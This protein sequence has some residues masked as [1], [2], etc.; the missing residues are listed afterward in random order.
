MPDTLVYRTITDSAGRFQLFPL[1]RGEYLAYG[2]LDNNHNMQ[3]DEREPYDSARVGAGTKEVPLL[4]IYPHDSVGPRLSGAT[5]TDSTAV[6]LAFTQP[7]DPYQHFDSVKVE[8]RQLPDSTLLPVRS[9]R[10]AALDDSIQAAIK[11][12]ADSLRADSAAKDTTQAPV[13]RPD[14]TARRRPL[15]PSRSAP[16]DSTEEK[17][18]LAQRPALF[19][20]LVLRPDSAFKPGTKYTVAVFG[21]RNVNRAAAD[22]R[23][24]FGIPEPKKEEPKDS[25][26]AK[27]EGVMTP[28]DSA[29][30]K[31]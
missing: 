30:K 31:Q 24:G 8:L 2:I 25:T 27:P 4:W 15:V 6:T 29:A 1:P 14:T 13:P 11:A 18:L 20:K 12:H 10:P 21:V 26:V 28:A 16:S 7:L 3:R 5:P 17:G 9:L 19:D 22:A 23:T